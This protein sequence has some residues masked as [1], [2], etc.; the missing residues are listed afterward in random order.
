MPP[1]NSSLSCESER[2]LVIMKG[3]H[4]LCEPL[5]CALQ[6]ITLER[7]VLNIKEVKISSMK[8]MVLIIIK[9]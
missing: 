3:R 1:N 5:V 4:L 9:G 7:V 2:H 6:K 8:G